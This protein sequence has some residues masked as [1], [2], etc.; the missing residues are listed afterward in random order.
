MNQRVATLLALVT[1]IAALTLSLTV[2]ITT[3]DD[4]EGNKRTEI[5]FR[6]NEAAGD[7]APTK[8]VEVPEAVVE[9]AQPTLEKRL[10]DETPALAEQVAPGQLTAAQEEA[11]RIRA[12]EPPLPTAGAS[13][14]FAGCVTRYVRNQSSRRG[15][16]PQ[17]QVLHYTV[18]PNRIGWAD[19]N[20][21]VALFDRASFAAS[22]HFVIDGE[23][24]CAYI[25][26]LE[27]K[28]WTQAAANPI[29]V[30]YEIINSGREAALMGGMGYAKLRAVMQQVAERTGI[31]LRA[32]RVSGCVA[33]QTGIVQHKD[34]GICGGG[35]VDITPYSSA[36]VIKTVSARQAVPKAVKWKRS[37]AIA[38]A[39]LRTC[40]ARRGHASGSY[41]CRHYRERNRKLH[42][43]LVRE[44]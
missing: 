19:V 17:L 4:G 36:A 40:G 29:S 3:S 33:T 24:N 1:A 44:A 21:I 11:A 20:A 12:T 23:G 38:H 2:A 22:S 26:P 13:P 5:S 41:F 25:V 6:V 31:P 18:S 28:A 32:G 43:L 7:G 27:A 42:A 10:R 9:Q 16:R 34:F 15:V 39:K 8:T 35:H 37:H 30:S 14:D